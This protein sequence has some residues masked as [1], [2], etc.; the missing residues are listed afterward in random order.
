MALSSIPA[1]TNLIDQQ[2]VRVAGPDNMVENFFYDVQ[3]RSLWERDTLATTGGLH[4]ITHVSEDPV[5][6]ATYEL[7]GLMSSDDKFRLD[8]LVQMRLGVLGFQG[9]GFPDDGGWIVGDAVLAAGSSFIHLE[10][11]G[12]IIRFVVDSPIPL[13]CGAEAC[14]QI[15]WVQDETEVNSIRPPSCAGKLPGLSGYGELRMYLLPDS[16]IVNT[17][18]P[19]ATLNTKGRYPALIFKRYSNSITPGS[20]EFHVVLKRDARNTLQTAVGWSMT[21]GLST[22]GECV[23]FMGSDAT[24][25]VVRFELSPRLEPGA[26]GALLYNGTSITKS[27]AIITGYTT[28]ALL[29]NQYTC[30]WWDAKN[31]TTSTSASFTA[32]N[33]WQ[34]APVG[35]TFQI[36]TEK[37]AG[38]V[39]VGTIIDVWYV[40]LGVVAGSPQ[41]RYYFNHRPDIRAEDVWYDLD[42]IAFGDTLEARNDAGVTGGETGS[43][44]TLDDHRTLEF[45]SWGIAGRYAPVA[46]SIITGSEIAIG[47][48]IASDF[49]G[50][51]DQTIPGLVVSDTDITGGGTQ[52]PFTIWHRKNLR[53]ALITM[54]IGRPTA[55]A[56]LP[57]FDIMACAPI[58]SHETMFLYPLEIKAVTGGGWALVVHGESFRDI[59]EHGT[60]R[61]L[62]H[63]PGAVWKYTRKAL[64]LNT[65]SL[66]TATVLFSDDAF[67]IDSRTYITSE[68]LELLH[69]DYT[70]P[71]VRFE[72]PNPAAN[73][74]QLRVKAGILGAGLP[75][76]N[77]A[78]DFAGDNY[79]CGLEPGYTTSD[80]YAQ[81]GTFTG[82]GTQPA[83]SV[84]GFVMY[85]GGKVSGTEYWNELEVMIKDEQAWVWWNGVIIPPSTLASTQLPQPVT[86]TTPYFP[87]TRITE[88][89]KVALRFW[90]G[91]VIRHINLRSNC[92]W[93]SVYSHGQLEIS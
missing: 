13:S 9:A 63:N 20:A 55:N 50:F 66:A 65:G 16:A 15:F 33:L 61:C 51:I 17:S 46:D 64:P 86:V 60:L 78:T 36:V 41:L 53:N 40:T 48:T 77:N 23:W 24:G 38:L 32:T 2:V 49:G 90:P 80:L 83:V 35:T 11:F 43:S 59:P 57:G 84:P 31:F 79:V 22:L 70:G 8:S 62:S 69:D 3:T 42:N 52:R 92:K 56:Q 81:S 25:S 87:L 39:D 88:T 27:P 21:P 76:E 14:A 91:C 72:F 73:I 5:P 93:S 30:K 67:P 45:N 75:Y 89:G 37:N 29:T 34:C 1:H 47:A 85:D 68:L 10:R 19:A 58:D 82:V 26:L 71:C 28:Q 12:N 7:P 54:K 6:A 4:G 44:F 18:N 74:H